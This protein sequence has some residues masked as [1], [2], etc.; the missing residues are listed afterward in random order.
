M[1]RARQKNIL[2]W[3]EDENGCLR[4]TEV[5][6]TPWGSNVVGNRSKRD[7]YLLWVE[8]FRRMGNPVLFPLSL[9]AFAVVCSCK[10][11]QR[12]TLTIDR[13]AL[14][15][16]AK[17]QVTVNGTVPGPTIR[18]EV[19]TLVEV[20]VFNSLVNESTLVHWHG[21]TQYNTPYSDGV[22]GVTQVS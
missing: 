15:G 18:V 2:H 22:P 12:Y 20:K 13:R 3:W 16:H 11:M 9:L 17:K 19:G 4:E 14:S 21:M 10:K 7:R 6:A 8:K 5:N 1:S